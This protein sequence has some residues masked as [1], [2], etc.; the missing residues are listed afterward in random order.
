MGLKELKGFEPLGRTTISTNQI[1][2]NSQGLS[3]QRRSTHG[4]S[5]IVAE[6]GL[7]MHQWKERSLVL[8][9]LDRCPNVGEIEGKKV[10]M[11]GYTPHRRREREGNWENK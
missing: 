6:D 4:S 2:Q 1:P 7:V 10:G 9:R 8:Y 11:G 3:H 5:C